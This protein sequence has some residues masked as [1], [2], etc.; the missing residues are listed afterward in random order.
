MNCMRG[1]HPRERAPRSPLRV[2]FPFT[3]TGVGGSYVSASLLARKLQ[4][5]GEVECIVVL[6][7]R[8]LNTQVFASEG[9]RPT[10]Y[11]LPRRHSE[12]LEDTTS[13]IRK[14]VAARA[15]VAAHRLALRSLRES[16]PDVV[17]I[18]DDRTMLSWGR[19]AK[20]LRIPV[21]WHIRQRTGTWWLDR[22]RMRLADS[23]VFITQDARR[24]RLAISQLSRKP[25]TVIHNA[26]DDGRFRPPGDRAQAK[27]LL[28][29][30][31]DSVVLSYV[32]TLQPRKR[33]EW[34]VRAGIELLQRGRQV[35]ILV[36]GGDPI[37]GAVQ[38][39]LKADVGRAG[40]T[41]AFH[42]LGYRDDIAAILRA[43]DILGLPSIAEPFGRVVIE[44]MSSGAAVV[45]T[46][47]GGVPEIID[48]G[49]NGLLVPPDDYAGFLAACD[50]LVLDAGLRRDLA[51]HGLETA[52]ER[53]SPRFMGEQ[54]L[55]VYR[56]LLEARQ[57]GLGR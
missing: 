29:L 14:V 10:Y 54:V 15:A 33:P 56:E 17:H 16:S 1:E 25:N 13:W 28:G 23:L 55:R 9:L 7:A 11:D 41:D 50:S 8:G 45:A 24:H 52:K 21:V 3:G 22:Y 43:T 53:F 44:A 5:S 49:I 32:G 40:Y 39:A 34:V 27:A 31:E 42:L 36:V 20:R 38:R 46:K 37:G 19:A 2:L 57:S 47:A 6:P 12:A 4:E 18:H 26:V 30:R 51:Q 48:H 35:Q